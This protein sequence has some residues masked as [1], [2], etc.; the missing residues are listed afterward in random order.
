VARYNPQSNASISTNAAS[1]SSTPVSAGHYTIKFTAS[2]L[3][4]L[5]A[6]ISLRLIQGPLND[7]ESGENYAS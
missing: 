5:S 6:M 4:I 7:A 2:A 1:F 3:M